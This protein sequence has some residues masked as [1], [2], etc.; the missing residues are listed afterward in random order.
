[1]ANDITI[2]PNVFVLDTAGVITTKALNIQAIHWLGTTD[3][4]DL[5]ISD[6]NGNSIW[7]QKLGT[8]LT[9]GLDRKIEFCRP[10]Q[11]N[12]LEVT[13]IDA[14]TVYVYLA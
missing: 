9:S 13:T 6:K 4:H 10:I 14:G 11:V 1:M 3:S 8:I 5:D 2:T 7:L 12:G